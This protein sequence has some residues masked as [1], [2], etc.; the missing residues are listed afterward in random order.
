MVTP[1]RLIVSAG[2]AALASTISGDALLGTLALRRT[3]TQTRTRMDREE[4][5]RGEGEVDDDGNPVVL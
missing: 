5:E 4:E 2:A 3:R 1:T